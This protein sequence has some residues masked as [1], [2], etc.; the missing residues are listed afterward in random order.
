MTNARRRLMWGILPALVLGMLVPAIS[1]AAEA[2][3][4]KE[5]R[6]FPDLARRAVDFWSDGTRLAGDLTYPK[7]MDENSNLPAIVL[8]HGWGGM[9]AHLN[10]AI[11]PQFAAAGYMVLAFD[12]RGWGASDSR[13]AV[14]GKIPKAGED[15]MVSV[16]AQAITQLVAPFD[17]QLDIA[18]AISFIEGEPGVDRNRIGLW[19]SSF[20][21]GHVMFRAAHDDRVKCIISQVSPMDLVSVIQGFFEELNMDFDKIKEERIQRA[22]GDIPSVPQKDHLIQG[23]NGTPEVARFLEF[24]A[25]DHTDK[26]NIPVLIIDAEK[27]HYFDIKKQGQRAYEQL[28]G[29]VPVEYHVLKDMAHYGVYSGEGLK[30]IMALEID[31]FNT[32]LKGK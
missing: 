1:M 13:L 27:E 24:V 26:V 11:A 21:G 20:G 14:N 25:L 2:G 8:C 12:Y 6:N 3:E 23:L 15:G 22:R 4:A 17:Q 5:V 18:A 7:D 30:K 32:H 10:G 29:R 9:K 19:G 28:K 16:S 31:W